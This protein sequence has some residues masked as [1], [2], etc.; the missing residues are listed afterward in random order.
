MRGTFGLSRARPLLGLVSPRLSVSMSTM[1]QMVLQ[2]PGPHTALHLETVIYKNHTPDKNHVRIKVAA[3]AV[4]Y[5]D[6]IDR[7]GGFPFMNRPTVLGHEFAGV[8]DAAGPGCSLAVGDRV[9]SLHWAQHG[10]E[11]FPSPFAHEA[12][13]KSFLGLTCNGGYA[14]Y[15]TTHETAFVAVPNADKWSAVYAA[16]VMST[17]GTV[18][19]GA[20]VRGKLSKGESG[21]LCQ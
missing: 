17:F 19:Q 20:I 2:A 18:W 4:A 8:V 16:P 9:V 12:A 14:D 10:G 13:M 1:R 5:R 3:C 6:I 11:A 21:Q 7:S 15:V